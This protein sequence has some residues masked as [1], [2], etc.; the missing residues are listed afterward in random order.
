M[1]D[2]RFTLLIAIE[3]GDTP[4]HVRLRHFLKTAL[5]RWGIRCVTITPT[6]KDEHDGN[7][8]TD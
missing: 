4:A 2:E 8:T 5:R 7:D 6:N 3:P 1:D